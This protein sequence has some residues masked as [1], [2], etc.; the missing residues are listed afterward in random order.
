MTSHEASSDVS[1]AQLLRRLIA[2][3]F[4]AAPASR[5]G[6]LASGSGIELDCLAIQSFVPCRWTYHIYSHLL[7]LHLVW[8]HLPGWQYAVHYTIYYLVGLKD[9]PVLHWGQLFWPDR[10]SS[11]LTGNHLFAATCSNDVIATMDTSDSYDIQ[12][13]ISNSKVFSISITWYILNQLAD[14]A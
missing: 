7:F 5:F 9:Q 14:R 10:S 11:P 13:H 1:H 12:Y 8:H 6:T 2:K 3:N 4:G